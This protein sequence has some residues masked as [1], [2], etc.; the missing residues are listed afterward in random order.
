VEQAMNT[1]FVSCAAF[2]E[3]ELQLTID[4]LFNNADKPQN[5]HIGVVQQC[6]RAERID[7]S[8]N[9]IV[10][11]IYMRA[12]A[13]QGA[14]F[15]R[16][17][18]QEMYSGEDFFMQ[19]DSHTRMKPHWDTD[20]INVYE[21]A[22]KAAG[23]EKII[24]SQFPSPYIYENKEDID[25][26]DPLYPFEPMKQ[27]LMWSKRSVWTASRLPFNDP[28]M[29]LPEES[30][31]VLAGFI[32]A[33]GVIV[34]EVPYDPEIS[35]FGEELCFAIRAW[36]KGWKIYSPNKMVIK[37]FYQR[38]G[39]HKVWNINN[40]AGKKWGGIEKRSMDK[41]AAIYNGDILG[42]WGAS[43]KD[44]LNE[45]FSFVKQDVPGLYNEYLYARAVAAKTVTEQDIFPEG[46]TKP[47]SI[48][49]NDEEHYKC[50][51]KGCECECHTSAG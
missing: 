35:F 41:Q 4:S 12:Q 14:G 6:T 24:L 44:K 31:T 13:A 21:S 22:A 17:K 28:R 15:A 49:C 51:V 48:S 32:F 46:I 27:A 25:V 20:L 8:G 36:T 9:P 30:E 43:T 39:H 7:F 47:M 29:R 1:I 42:L 11:D 3:P 38:R 40:N 33:P 23:T 37:H 18:A 2:R 19:I 26:F 50:I 16:A 5:L 34:S 45:Y 10:S